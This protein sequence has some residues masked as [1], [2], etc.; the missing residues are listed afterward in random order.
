MLEGLEA[1]KYLSNNDIYN[2][3]KDEILNLKLKPGQPLSENTVAKRFGVSRTP[4]RTVF[5]YLIKDGLLEV[6]PRRGTFVTLLDPDAINQ[7]IYIRT[8]VETGIMTALARQQ[9][10]HLFEKLRDNLSQQEQQLET[11][12]TPMSFYVMDSRF[13]EL[14][15]EALGRRRLWKIIQEISVHYTRYRMLD[16]VSTKRFRAL[17]KEHCAL[18]D[19]MVNGDVERIEKQVTE[20]LCGGI[21]GIGNRLTTE[22]RDYFD[23]SNKPISGLLE[24]AHL[25]ID[26]VNKTII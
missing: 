1:K 12:M 9:D 8:K 5:E 25:M 11:G 4:V 7:I 17:Y 2:I 3:V 15:M 14:C 6:N 19:C 21:I 23:E 20:H 16:Y 18:Y 26:L 24:D 10:Q 22:F 13:H